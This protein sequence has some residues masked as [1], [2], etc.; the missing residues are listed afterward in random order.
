MGI[1]SY[2]STKRTVGVVEITPFFFTLQKKSSLQFWG[3]RFFSQRFLISMG[4]QIRGVICSDVGLTLPVKNTF[5]LWM[6]LLEF[7]NLSLKLND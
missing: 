3:R 4:M 1:C 6:V 7:Q 5:L 2:S